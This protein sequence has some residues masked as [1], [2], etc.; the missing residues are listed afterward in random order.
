MQDSRGRLETEVRKVLHEVSRIA[1]E[2]LVR[3]HKLKEEGQPAAEAKLGR[4]DHLEKEVFVLAPS[5]DTAPIQSRFTRGDKLRNKF[6]SIYCA[7]HCALRV[8]PSSSAKF[9]L[10]RSKTDSQS[11]GFSLNGSHLGIAKPHAIHS[12]SESES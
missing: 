5:P 10:E 11:V 3:A 6:S 1:K 12:K 2:A 8:P 7:G 9:L 4:L